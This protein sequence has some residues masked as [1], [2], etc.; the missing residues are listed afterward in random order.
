MTTENTIVLKDST[1]EMSKRLADAGL[2]V[3][4]DGSVD[5]PDGLFEKA[6][7]G[8]GLGIAD[9]KKVHDV[10]GTFVSGAGHCIGTQ[11]VAVMSKHK[12]VEAVTAEIAI[13]KDKLGVQLNRSQVT[14]DGKGGQTT[15]H[16]NLSMKYSVAGAGN[17][18]GELK[19]VRQ[20]IREQASKLLAD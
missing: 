8:S 14:P 19:K 13:V 12:D 11:G 3:L 5:V 1:L 10:I 6:L 7:E 9:V 18:R 15:I 4:K 16:G 2:K 17:T 20:S